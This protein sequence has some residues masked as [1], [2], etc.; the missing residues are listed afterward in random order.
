MSWHDTLARKALLGGKTSQQF[1]Q[2]AKRHAN[3]T[4]F[5]LII[6]CIVWYFADWKWALIPFSLAAFVA[7]QSFSATM[8]ATRLKRFENRSE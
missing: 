2:A 6:G 1:H 5:Y 4:W 3:A 7:F 8:V